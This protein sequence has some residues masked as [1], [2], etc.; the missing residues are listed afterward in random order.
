[1]HVFLSPHY[2]DAVYS[3]GGTIYQ[4][5]QRGAD[6]LI[7]T[8]MGGDPPDPPPDT[9]IVRD[10][11]IRWDSGA[12]PIDARRAEDRAAAAILGAQV[13]HLPLPDC[14]Y[15]TDAHGTP[16]YPSES[17][18]WH[19]VHPDDPAR[20]FLE[21]KPI[22]PADAEH[23]YAPLGVG[24]H[25]DHLLVH[26]WARTL[27]GHVRYYPD[28]PY[29]EQPGAVAA[30]VAV[31]PFAAKKHAVL[32]T[33]AAIA[34]KIEGVRAY[35]SQVSTFWEDDATLRARVRAALGSPPQEASYDGE[36]TTGKQA[37]RT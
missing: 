26:Q 1:M 37:W 27:P 36:P 32:L 35:T 10:L 31:L 6:V 21:R 23:V 15:R 7:I 8:I 13:Q 29:T 3:C 2:D 30:A 19:T 33:E 4:L 9:P 22:I 12:A 16:L 5:A 14:V 34:A 20:A 17:S 28:F 24:G 11:H 18:L 25:V